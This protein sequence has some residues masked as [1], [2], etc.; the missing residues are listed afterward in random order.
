MA[1]ESLLSRVPIP[2]ANVH[3]IRTELGE[4]AAQD[5]ESVLRDYFP[6]DRS[7]TFDLVLLGMGPDGHTASLFPGTEALREESRLIVPNWVEKLKQRRFT[8]TL[9]AINRA[10]R[11]VFTVVGKDKASILQEV[12]GGREADKYPAQLVRPVSGW[13]QWIVDEGAAQLL[14]RKLDLRPSA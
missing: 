10:P 6:D 13:L 11:V 12:L 14:P 3:R 9:P 7:N 2:P 8:L 4:A 1:Q 5:Y